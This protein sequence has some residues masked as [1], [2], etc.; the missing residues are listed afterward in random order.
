MQNDQQA[1]ARR[2]SRSR[3]HNDGAEDHGDAAAASQHRHDPR[4]LRDGGHS[5]DRHGARRSSDDD[6]RSADLSRRREAIR[7]GIRLVRQKAPPRGGSLPPPRRGS[8]R[9]ET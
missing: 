6:L 8:P 4:P 9:R 1:R 2:R 3:V 7:I 5:R